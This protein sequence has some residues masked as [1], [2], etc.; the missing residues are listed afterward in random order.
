MRPLITRK[1]CHLFLCRTEKKKKKERKLAHD[2]TH[3]GE[4]EEVHASPPQWVRSAV[5]CH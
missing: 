4:V 1:I 2:V 3:A 5:S